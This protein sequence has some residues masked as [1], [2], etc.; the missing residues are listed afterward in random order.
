[1]IGCSDRE[2]KDMVA[3]DLG[4]Y[5]SQGYI[6]E[7]IDFEEV[8]KMSEKYTCKQ[9]KAWGILNDY[10]H[11]KC[12]PYC[13]K[14]GGQSHEGEEAMPEEDVL[15]YIAT[16]KGHIISLCHQVYDYT[17]VSE[18][19]SQANAW[20]D[21][22][23]ERVEHIRVQ[24]CKEYGELMPRYSAYAENPLHDGDFWYRGRNI[25][26]RIRELDAWAMDQGLRI[27]RESPD[28]P[29]VLVVAPADVLAEYKRLKAEREDEE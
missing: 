26:K 28:K 11:G 17:P 6:I 18:S 1:M 3:R 29:F 5:M 2:E 25:S 7:Q 13:H 20:L 16:P 12:C 9:L 24:V 10:D 27:V 21:E 4:P 22:E 19:N 23:I 8:M 15:T 14:Q